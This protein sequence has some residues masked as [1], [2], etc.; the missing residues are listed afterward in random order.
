MSELVISLVVAMRDDYLHV[1]HVFYYFLT[2]K[3]NIQLFIST[4][5]KNYVYNFKF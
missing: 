2:L 1:C 3:N 4:A 5:D